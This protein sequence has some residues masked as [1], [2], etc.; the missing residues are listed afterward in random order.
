MS[1]S[2][3]YKEW[4]RA[5]MDRTSR[6]YNIIDTIIKDRGGIPVLINRNPTIGYGSILQMFCVGA[7]DTYTMGMPLQVLKPLGADFDG[8]TMNILYIINQQFFEAANGVFNP[9]NALYISRNDGY[10]NNQINH[11]RDT[12]ITANA[13]V[14]LSRYNYT[15]AE[16]EQI[17]KLKSIK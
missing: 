3:A 17:E 6:V 2:D 14:Y 11:C 12:L 16:K 8:D 1:Y 13:L 4:N 15:D 10:F 9:R 5:Q 7:T